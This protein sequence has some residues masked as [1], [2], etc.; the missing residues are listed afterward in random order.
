[1]IMASVGSAARSPRN[2]APVSA[3]PVSS[4]RPKSMT[5][6]TTWSATPAAMHATG[7]IVNPSRR[8]ARVTSATYSSIRPDATRCE[9]VGRATMPR[10]Y[11]IDAEGDLEDDERQPERADR[12]GGE[13]RAEA[14]EHEQGQLAAGEAERAGTEEDER[15]AGLCVAR[16]RSAAC[17]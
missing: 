17:T 10:G 12:A 14:G 1:M 5:R 2:A 8:S 9:S 4:T 6:S 16:G 3:M 15:P 13:R 11:A 7:S